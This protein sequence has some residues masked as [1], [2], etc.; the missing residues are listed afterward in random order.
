MR[1]EADAVKPKTG[2]GIG[3]DSNGVYVDLSSL[4]TI[5]S[6]I[7]K[8]KNGTASGDEVASVL[9]ALLTALGS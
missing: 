4:Q 1:K 5:S 3:V 6:T 9:S 8:V 2:G 7:A